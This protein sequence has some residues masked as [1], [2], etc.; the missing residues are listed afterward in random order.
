MK[1]DFRSHGVTFTLDALYRYVVCY[2]YGGAQR[3]IVQPWH[4][5]KSVALPV[6]AHHVFTE[7]AKLRDGGDV[8]LIDTERQEVTALARHGRVI[9]TEHTDNESETP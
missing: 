6:T 5:F 1:C 2:R 9:I 3:A 7:T 8:Y 4:G